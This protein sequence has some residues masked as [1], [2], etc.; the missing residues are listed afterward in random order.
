MS[1]DSLNPRVPRAYRRRAR[2]IVA[3]GLSGLII[4]TCGLVNR[5]LL[6]TASVAQ[7]LDGPVDE[8]WLLTYA[9]AGLLMAGGV[10]FLRPGVEAVGLWLM[11]ATALINAVAVFANRGPIGGGITSSSLLLAAWVIQSRLGDLHDAAR[12]DR[13]TVDLGAQ[14]RRRPGGPRRG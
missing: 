12:S 8:L 9:V 4:G 13:R 2:V 3:Y 14:A 6:G 1:P 7:A 11:L 5:S 10:T